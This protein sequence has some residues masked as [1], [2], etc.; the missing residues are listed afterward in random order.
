MEHDLTQEV[1][2]LLKQLGTHLDKRY[3]KERLV[4]HPDFPSA[5]CITSLLDELSISNN[6]IELNLDDLQSLNGPALAFVDGKSF[7]FIKDIALPEKSIPNFSDRWNGIVILAQKESQS[8]KSDELQK[9]E[10]QRTLKNT[11]MIL[12]AV[13]LISLA[14]ILLYNT[15][16]KN[17]YLFGLSAVGA[18]L[19]WQ[20]VLV[21]LGKTSDFS[22][23]IC[24]E[25]NSL[26]CKS[27]IQEFKPLPFNIH[28]SDISMFF[29]LGIINL[30]I[31]KEG[32]EWEDITNTIIQLL[33]Y[34]SSVPLIISIYYQQFIVKKW[35]ALC[36]SISICLC[37]MI[38][39]AITFES[40][41][42]VNLNGMF[43][44]IMCIFLL[45][46]I[47]WMNLRPLIE[48]RNDTLTKNLLL[49]RFKRNPDLF[50][51][52]LL[53]Q[54]KEVCHSFPTDLQI[55]N[56]KAPCQVVAVISPVCGPCSEAFDILKKLKLRYTEQIG[57]TI[58]FALGNQYKSKMIILK[59]MLSY[60]LSKDGFMNS[61]KD[62]E[63]MLD[64]WYQ[65][66]DV[67]KFIMKYPSAENKALIS[68]ISEVQK[69]IKNS[70]IYY[71]PTIIINGYRL[72]DPYTF[73]DLLE[74]GGLCLEIFSSEVDKDSDDQ[75]NC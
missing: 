36:I 56:S 20:A 75:T 74:F 13:T 64:T 66:T 28:I 14:I 61:P 17:I 39:L 72:H 63:T 22:I 53:N 57:I 52:R 25:S 4:S 38:L 32:R 65:N 68:Y 42:K 10:Q 6:A 35:C 7:Y 46:G 23:K 3:I 15:A 69:W 5:F 54:N 29:F 67:D 55:G 26:S 27:V 12:L 21:E 19:S 2:R 60:A 34:V 40:Q 41:T 33:C 49:K 48:E 43:L 16:P 62:I 70:S 51:M 50:K 59:A 8:F 73:D 47:I 31:I 71:T 11:W 30:V 44:S 1:Y 18:F 45:P 24:R 37:L 58:R 9:I